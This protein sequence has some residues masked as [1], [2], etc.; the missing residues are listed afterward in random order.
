MENRTREKQTKTGRK[1]KV[2]VTENLAH[3]GGPRF[4]DVATIIMLYISKLW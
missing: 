1:R 3:A 2:L 4:P